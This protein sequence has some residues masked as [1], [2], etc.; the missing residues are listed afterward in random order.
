MFIWYLWCHLFDALPYGNPYMA[1]LAA[2]LLL[3]ALGMMIKS[4]MAA[5]CR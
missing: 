3:T 5:T 4:V 2:V 1:T